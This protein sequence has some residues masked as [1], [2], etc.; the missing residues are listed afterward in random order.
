MNYLKRYRWWDEGKEKRRPAMEGN[1]R[2]EFMVGAFMGLGYSGRVMF[3]LQ[4]M[5][6]GSCERG[7]T[8]EADS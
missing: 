6:L 4:G 5:G 3:R 2:P 1:G 8:G 7:A